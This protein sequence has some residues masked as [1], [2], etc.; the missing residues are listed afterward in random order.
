VK[1][2]KQHQ[3]LTTPA[4]VD[5][6]AQVAR[7]LKRDLLERVADA[8]ADRHITITPAQGIWRSLREG[9][10][11]MVLRE[12]AGGVKSCLLRIAP[13]ATVPAHRHLADEEC[14]VLSGHVQ[15]GSSPEL[16]PGTYHLAAMG[17]LHAT[18]RSRD[19]ATIFLRGTLPR[20]EDF[21]HAKETALSENTALD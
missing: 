18:I 5:L 20:L 1:S 6:S 14:V 17:N 3:A 4:Q 16:G 2:N 13:G 19:G 15:V 9:V 11:L 21:L 7:V 8:D 12:H 10:G